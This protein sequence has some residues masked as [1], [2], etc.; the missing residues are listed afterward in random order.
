[1]IT[2]EQP[3]TTP[4]QSLIKRIQVRPYGLTCILDA[5]LVNGE[6]TKNATVTLWSNQLALITNSPTLQDASNHDD[7]EEVAI[8]MQKN[9][10]ELKSLLLGEELDIIVNLVDR[11]LDSPTYNDSDN[12]LTTHYQSLEAKAINSALPQFLDFIEYSPKPASPLD[13]FKVELE[14]QRVELQKELMALQQDTALEGLRKEIADLKE[15]L[16]PKKAPAKKAR[17]K[18]KAS[19]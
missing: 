14:A 17:A 8:W 18:R 11:E 7:R 10:S 4:I 13:N 3:T 12:L 16:K 9:G 15:S 5:I 2:I 1:M 6:Y 19:K